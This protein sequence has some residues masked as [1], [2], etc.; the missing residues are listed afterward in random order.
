[1]ESYVSH[2]WP[3]PGADDLNNSCYLLSRMLCSNPW[4][5]LFLLLL[6][7]I[8]TKQVCNKDI[9]F[10]LVVLSQQSSQF[11][12]SISK[13]IPA[14]LSLFLRHSRELE[15]VFW[16]DLGQSF[17]TSVL[18]WKHMC[19]ASRPNSVITCS[20]VLV[21]GWCL[22]MLIIRSCLSWDRLT[23]LLATDF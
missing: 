17:Y 21:I 1:M 7:A 22:A 10:G 9:T 2:H 12:N 15:A 6:L 3:N 20:V 14:I 19:A 18:P 5:C 11:S 4:N 16:T 8:W 23:F 13:E